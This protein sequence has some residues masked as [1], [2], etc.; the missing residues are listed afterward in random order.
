MGRKCK[1]KICK[2]QL[3]TDTAYKV[4]I[5]GKNT[6]YCN[7]EEYDIYYEDI[8][9][10]K[11]EKEKCYDTICNILNIPFLTPMYIKQL[12]KLKEFYD[13]Y[14][15]ERTFKE[16]E[17][18]ILWFLNKNEDSSEYG[19]SRYIMTIIINNIN[20]IYKKIKKEKEEI[21]DLFNKS[22]IENPI[23][24]FNSIEEREN[25]KDDT[26]VDITNFLDD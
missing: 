4:I 11:E 25:K 22:N 10:R 15:I 16:C 14:T 13:Y 5:N 17:N 18:N 2:N 3:N 6:Y 1:C 9:K 21:L 19:K 23:E 20:T 7:K 8:N 26:I 12:N 24:V